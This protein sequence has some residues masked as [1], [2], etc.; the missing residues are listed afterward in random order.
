MIYLWSLVSWRALRHSRVNNPSTIDCTGTTQAGLKWLKSAGYPLPK[1]LRLVYDPKMHY[2]TVTFS[3]STELKQTLTLPA[4]MQYEEANWLY[5]FY[6]DS[7][8]GNTGFVLT[9]MDSDTSEFQ[10]GLDVGTTNDISV[11]SIVQLCCGG[12]GDITLP[13]APSEIETYVRGVKGR[14][15]VPDWVVNTVRRLSEDGKPVFKLVRIRESV[16]YSCHGVGD[17]LQVVSWCYSTMLLYPLSSSPSFTFQSRC[18]WRFY[19]AAGPY[20]CVCERCFHP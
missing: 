8:Y 5:T 6:A 2:T 9:K 11:L 17:V 13:R 10:H 4:G 15:E 3:V 20:I 1:S 19:D 14:E 16:N 7:K 12:W 18:H